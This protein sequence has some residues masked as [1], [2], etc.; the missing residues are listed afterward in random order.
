M[1]PQAKSNPHIYKQSLTTSSYWEIG[2]M[3]MHQEDFWAWY[4]E[5]PLFMKN[6]NLWY[7]EEDILS[8]I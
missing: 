1:C 5:E 7:L 3:Y 2:V 8:T 6:E 4:L